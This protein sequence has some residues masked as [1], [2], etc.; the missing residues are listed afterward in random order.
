MKKIGEIMA[1]MGFRKEAPDSVKEA[2]LKHLIKN[3]TGA[4]VETPT[5]KKISTSKGA[6]SKSALF[7]NEDLKQEPKQLSFDFFQDQSRKK[8]KVS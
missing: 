3:V 2:F 1:E 7:Q 8:A 6:Q 5:E 4:E